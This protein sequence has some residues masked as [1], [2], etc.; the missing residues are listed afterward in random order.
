MICRS[1]F[2]CMLIPV[3][4]NT[5]ALTITIMVCDAYWC[6]SLIGYSP[7][8]GTSICKVYTESRLVCKE[9]WYPVILR[10]GYVILCPLETCLDV[11]AHQW[12]TN[13]RSSRLHANTMQSVSNGLS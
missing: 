2:P 3:Q 7:H 11:V 8:P 1:V 4:T 6:E 13:G 5:E 10:P 9:D 12:N